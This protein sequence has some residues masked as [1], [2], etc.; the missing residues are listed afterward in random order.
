MAKYN[1]LLTEEIPIGSV[2]HDASLRGKGIPES[3]L[4]LAAENDIPALT[5]N[6]GKFLTNNGSSMSWAAVSV[7]DGDKGDITVSSSG[8]TY[9]IDA[10]VVSNSKLRQ[11][12][13]LSVI[14]R[15]ADTLGNVADITG[16]DGQVLRVSGTTLGF[17][18]IATT[19]LPSTFPITAAPTS[20]TTVSGTTTTFTAN[21]NQ[22]F[23]DAVFINSSGKAQL[24]DADAI[25]TSGCIALCTATVTSNNTGTYLLQ[26]FARNDAWN[27]TV[28]GF[29][30]LSTT[31]TTTNTLTQTAP[32]GTDDV[33][34][35]LGVATHADRM[36]FNPQ[37]VQVEHV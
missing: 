25:A 14:G 5:G 1:R 37:L 30:Y 23:G 10:N 9:T 18:S 29:I 22:G 6:S 13:G 8:A 20:D 26:G 31:G 34:Q 3:P 33:I 7:S 11:S 16:T 19:A 12:A 32:S 35:I 2:A 28:G 4:K 36:Y 21:E 24:G 17:G 27:W 15:S